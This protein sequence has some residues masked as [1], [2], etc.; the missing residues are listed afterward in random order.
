MP[1]L[2]AMP[3]LA[4]AQVP[5]TPPA[6]SDLVPPDQRTRDRATTTLTIDGDFERAPCALD[7]PQYADLRF[8]LK[9]ARFD[10][11][12]R[13]AG[14]SLDEAFASYRER[15][16]PVSALCDIRARANA[17]LRSQGYLATVEIPE[18]SLAGGVPLFKVVFGRLA[19]VR[20]RGDAGRSERLVERYLSK[21]TAQDIFNTRDAERYLLLADDLPGL[22]V[23][24]SLRPAVEGE[25]GDLLGEIAVVSES[26]AIDVNVQNYGSDAIGRFGGLLRGEL[27][28]LT[29]LGDRTTLTAFS[30]LEFA[31]QHTFQIGHDFALGGEGLRIGTQ[32]TFSLTNPDINLPGFAIDSETVFASIFA[33]YPLVRRRNAS[34]HLDAGFDYAD[35]NVELNGLPLTRDRVR[36]MFARLSGE[37]TDAGSTQRQ[38]GYSPFEP[39]LRLRYQVEARQGLDVFSASPDCRPNLLACLAPG[40]VP[41]SRIEGN[42][43]PFVLRF[44]T[45]VEY[46]PA[47]LFTLSLRVNGQITGDALPAFEEY[48][49]GSFSIGR[50]YDPGTVLGDRGFGAAFEAR[51]GTL[52]PKGANDLAVQPYVFSDMVRVWNE[53]PSLAGLNPNRLWSA[54]GGLRAAWGSRMQGDVALAV[55]LERPLNAPQLGAVR[56]MV[57]LTARLFPWRF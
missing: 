57:S 22:S 44:D 34:L 27:Y 5:I 18:Q 35:Q 50:G 32:I 4:Q 19:S 55:P 33:S 31:E 20:V 26:G 16:V 36:V 42:P 14:L 54:G 30:T 17:I 7:Q 52:A 39:R 48:A 40:L 1:P 21:L 53:D 29:G 8:T 56:L 11:L 28:N 37:S 12:A 6:R 45:G 23:R 24:L 46:R 25:P 51:Y 38:G 43:Q 49:G 9:G 15:E 41:P 10:G 3:A 2:L 13:V 47:P